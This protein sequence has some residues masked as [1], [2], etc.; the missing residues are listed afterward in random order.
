MPGHA[1]L[2]AG[3][4]ADEPF[5]GANGLAGMQVEKTRC[6]VSAAMIE[7]LHGLE[8]AHLPAMI[9]SG[10]SRMAARTASA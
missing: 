1:L 8:I 9:T 7:G 3:K 6:P 5:D 2:I 4:V 10:S